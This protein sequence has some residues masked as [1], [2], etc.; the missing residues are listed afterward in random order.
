MCLENFSVHL[1]QLAQLLV[2]AEVRF[3]TCRL[4]NGDYAWLWRKCG[5]ERVL[6]LLMERKRAGLH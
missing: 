4:V 1:R 2:Q 3:R 6:P 5:E